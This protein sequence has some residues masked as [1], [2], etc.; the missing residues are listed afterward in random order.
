VNVD[1]GHTS[2]LLSPESISR[3]AGRGLRWSLFGI[4]TN[5]L[6]SFAIGLVLARILT[7]DDF[8]IYAL[9]LAAT[10]VVMHVNDVGIIAAT[11]Q[12]RGRIDEMAAT[13]ATLALAFSVTVYGLVWFATPYFAELAN[14]PKA[15]PVIRI[16]TSVILID[17]ITAIRAAALLRRFDQHQLIVANLVGWVVQ[18]PTTIVLA[19][20]GAGATSFAVGQV[21]GAAVTGVLVFA[22]ARLPVRVGFD[23]DVARKLLK[24]GMP[25]ALGLGVE[26][27]LVNTDYVIVGRVVGGTQL[28]FYVLAF[29]ISSWV[30][31]IL[32]TGVRYVSLAGF[33][34]MAEHEDGLSDA[35]HKTAPLLVT[36]VL[37]I[38]GLMAL[39]APQLVSFLY[40]ST[41]APAAPALAFLMLLVLA[42]VLSAFAID[43]LASLGSTRAALHLNLVWYAVLVPAL[44]VGSHVDGIRG[45]AI[46]HAV[47]G[48]VVA[49][50]LAVHILHRHGVRLGPILPQLIR[51]AGALAVAI[52]VCLV[53]KELAG[54]SA[55]VEL[56]VAGGAALAAYVAIVAPAGALD[57]VRRAMRRRRDAEVGADAGG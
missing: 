19:T 1:D 54:R 50:P 56:L 4:M 40:G 10:G 43:I 35:V 23:R 32:V 36:A 3:G 53:G 21:A 41:W 25:L 18:A 42:R 49:I 48:T 29:N 34:R 30:P 6:G 55:L 46:A 13:A 47:V 31:G 44:I 5:R 20:A 2:E 57:D 37:P 38:V 12:W 14:S 33:S 39:L 11:V 27:L 45:A 22:F 28:G 52:G 15:T 17:G 51:P 24:F 8:G 26:A 7:P 16:V 9:A